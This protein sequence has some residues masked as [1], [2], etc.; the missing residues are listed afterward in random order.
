MAPRR[1]SDVAAFSSRNSLHAGKG[2]D[3]VIMGASAG[4]DGD[5]A[6]MEDVLQDKRVHAQPYILNRQ[7]EL[8][9][10]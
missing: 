6:L 4:A 1:S 3:K 2:E 7:N 10:R 9:M 5:V 8:G